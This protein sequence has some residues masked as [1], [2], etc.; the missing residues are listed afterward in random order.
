MAAA[1]IGFAVLVS[2][3][4][5]GRARSGEPGQRVRL[6]VPL[7]SVRAPVDIYSPATNGGTLVAQDNG[8]IRFFYR[9]Y[10]PDDTA[11]GHEGSG[12]VL[13]EFPLHM[14]V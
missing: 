12:A 8:V 6:P 5:A 13:Y 2:W 3:T 9:L 7:S 1:V 10:Q 14:L 11:S 4:A